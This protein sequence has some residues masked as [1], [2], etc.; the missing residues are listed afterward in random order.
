[1]QERYTRHV[2]KSTFDIKQERKLLGVPLRDPIRNEE[3]KNRS[4]LV[5]AATETRRTKWRWGGHI[6]RM[7]QERWT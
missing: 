6:M 7:N 4:G 1:M 2:L 5:I 3:L